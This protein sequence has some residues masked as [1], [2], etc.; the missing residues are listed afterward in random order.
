MATNGNVNHDQYAAAPAQKTEAPAA[1]NNTITENSTR[2]LPKDEVGWYF[3]EQYY[4][5]LS[6]SPERLHVSI[7]AVVLGAIWICATDHLGSCSTARGRSSWLAS[8]LRWFLSQSV[9]M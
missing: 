4:T 3:V 9:V 7:S 2:D 6:K 5:T 1:N 8:R